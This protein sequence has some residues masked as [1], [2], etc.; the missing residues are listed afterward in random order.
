[1][2]DNEIHINIVPQ[3]SQ[4]DATPLVQQSDIQ[5]A[6]PQ[7]VVSWG[8]ILGNINDQTDLKNALDAKANNDDVVHKTGNE[9]IAGVKTFID[10]IVGNV[11][12]NASTAT[13]ATQDGDGNT[14]SSTYIKTSTKGVANGVASL[15]ANTKV[16]VAQIPDLSSTYATTSSLATVATSGSYNDLLNKPT[17]PTVN[18]AT[19]TIQ[20]NGSNVATFTANSSTNTTANITVP[21]DLS[22]L[23]NNSGFI[24]NDDVLYDYNAFVTSTPRRIYQAKLDNTLY[25]AD[26]RFTVTLTN[27]K[28]GSNYAPYLFDGNAETNTSI[29][30]GVSNATILIE[31]PSNLGMNYPY[32]YI[33]LGFYYTCAPTLLS[34]VS[35]RVY[36]NWEGHNVGW[37]SLTPEEV[38]KTGT[39]ITIMRFPTLANYGI[40]KIEI[41]IDN[42][43]GSPDAGANYEVR[44][45]D[46]AFFCNRTSIHSLPVMTKWGSD[47][48]YGN[49]TIPTANGS[50]VGNLSGTATKAAQDYDGNTITSTYL[51]LSGGTL[52]GKL[53]GTYVEAGSGFQVPNSSYLIFYGANNKSAWVNFDN[54]TEHLNITGKGNILDARDKAVANGVASLD[55]NTKIPSAQLPA[56][57]L[58]SLSNVTITSPS[59]GEALIYDSANQ[60]W[61]N[62]A[63]SSSAGVGYFDLSAGV[64]INSGDVTTQDGWIYI[65]RNFNGAANQADVSPR[66]YF[67]NVQ[68]GAFGA[69]ARDGRDGYFVAAW[70]T[71]VKSGVTVTAVNFND[72]IFYP[73]L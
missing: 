60:V 36:Q 3:E 12:G 68:V 23:T 29:E 22:N 14:I 13:K 56:I 16:P 58:D 15:D 54:S 33:Y 21:T 20:K 34:S 59:N 69:S 38:C 42:T 67:D 8:K 43:D 73:N 70:L 10:G 72:L 71:P 51:K 48:K 32:G 45:S 1:M 18:D 7:G 47:T 49:L 31:G 61:K 62:A 27:F 11:T 50:F 44:P 30:K 19:L 55:A 57:S 24:K 35:C 2:A 63:S 6:F 52:T 64:S 37:V 53:T 66:L 5:V 41:T 17:I 4:I 39:A 25:E 46:I 9:T 28:G 26:K 40:E 65:N